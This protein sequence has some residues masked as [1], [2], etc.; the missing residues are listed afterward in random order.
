[1]SAVDTYYAALERLKNG[2]AEIV[3]TNSHKFRITNRSVA[4]EAGKDGGNVR[5]TRYPELCE[6]I[7][8]AEAERLASIPDDMPSVTRFKGQAQREKKLKQNANQKLA[9]LKEKYQ[10]A[11]IQIMNLVA[12]NHRLR[13]EILDGGY[14]KLQNKQL[15]DL[16]GMD[17]KTDDPLF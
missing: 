11:L 15:N 14:Q 1:M 10:Q 9:E 16:V 12:E 3:D 17:V 13:K 7:K 8:K 6:A 5:E 2:T 4:R